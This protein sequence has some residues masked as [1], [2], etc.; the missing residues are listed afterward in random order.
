M[1]FCDLVGSTAISDRLDPEDFARLLRLYHDAIAKRVGAFGGH[2]AQC[3][4]DGLLVY[5]GYPQAHEDDPVRAVDAGLAILEEMRAVSREATATI[6]SLNQDLQARVAINTGTVV[7]GP[8]GDQGA[9][10]YLALG[11]SVAIAQ[12][13]LAACAPGQLV[14]SEATCRLLRGRFGVEDRGLRTL[15]GLEESVR[16]FS[17]FRPPAS[18]VAAESSER[19]RHAIVGR[20]EEI[21]FLLNRWRRA[22][23]GR[24]QVVAIAGEPGIGKS[25]VVRALRQRLEG[26]NYTRLVCRGAAYH[27]GSPFHAVIELLEKALAFEPEEDPTTKRSRLEH[28]LREGNLDVQQDLPFFEELLCLSPSPARSFHSSPD[29]RRRRILDRLAAWL[30]HL[31]EHRPVLLVVEDL[32]LLDASTL[33]LLDIVVERAGGSRILVVLTCRPEFERKWTTCSRISYLALG[34]LTDSE[35]RALV[36]TVAGRPLPASLVEELVRQTDGVPLFIEECVKN[37]TESGLLDRAPNTRTGGGLFEARI[38]VTLRDSLTARLD[39]TGSARKVAQVAAVLGREFSL[40]LLRAVSGFEPTELETDLGRLMRAG[41]LYRRGAPPNT[42]YFFTHA[43]VRDAAYASLLRQTRAALHR[44]VV[45][46][47]EKDAPT[48]TCNEPGVLARHCERGELLEKAVFYYGHAAQRAASQSA[49]GEASAELGRA[50]ELLAATPPS[51]DRDRQELWL[52]ML[53]GLVLVALSGYASEPVEKAFA[54]ARELCSGLET[55]LQRLLCLT[56][57]WLFHFMR[58]DARPA[59]ELSEE[60]QVLAREE[61]RPVAGMLA[62]VVAGLTAFFGGNLGVAEVHLRSLRFPDETRRQALEIVGQ[63]N[64]ALALAVLAVSSSL[65]GEHARAKRQR[66]RALREA[67]TLGHPLTLASTL[68]MAGMSCQLAE[69]FEEANALASRAVDISRQHG[70]PVWEASG[71]C[72]SSLAL[73][74]LGR[75]EEADLACEQGLEGFRRTGA[76][77]GLIYVLVERAS[78]LLGVS[79]RAGEARR[80]LE[81]AKRTRANG[82]D[83][84]YDAEISRVSG[85]LAAMEG[86]T[87]RARDHLRCAIETARAQGARLFELRAALSLARL[88]LHEGDSSG[89]REILGPV[90]CAFPTRPR[91]RA[92]READSLLHEVGGAAASQANDSV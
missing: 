75:R 63:D 80:Y 81:Y 87:G 21:A 19:K 3:L 17:V 82:L 22:V 91:T 69:R 58:S 70:I 39:R 49:M 56:G 44:R 77:T 10:E 65:R 13:L 8:T 32:Q 34:Q 16:V 42:T 74:C 71:L 5:F 85:E 14:I 90:Y 54:R 18:S 86:E 2:V 59:R 76:R 73:G 37:A 61:A 51:R 47:T 36:R 67:E 12:R 53:Q 46:V 9:P 64:V 7:T 40:R 20:E 84:L 89:A 68:V 27:S 52:R 28:A 30:L 31:A 26:E 41:L 4:G 33:E 6:P 38:P 25:T 50:L 11:Q 1:L 15:R 23:E 57:L 35:S 43:L 48:A 62:H 79:G 88:L 24:G 83:R 45:E 29:A 92:V 60:I 72:T 55:A 78:F 66:K